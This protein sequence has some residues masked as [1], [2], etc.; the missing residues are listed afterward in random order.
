MSQKLYLSFLHQKHVV[1][2]MEATSESLRL[3]LMESIAATNTE[4]RRG[5]M[6]EFTIKELED[7]IRRQTDDIVR[8]KEEVDKQHSENM[9]VSTVFKDKQMRC[10]EL[11]NEKL[12]LQL[13]YNRMN[14]ENSLHAERVKMLEIEIYEKTKDYRSLQNNFDDKIHDLEI[15]IITKNALLDREMQ[16]NKY[17]ADK[18]VLHEEKIDHLLSQVGLSESKFVMQKEQY[19]KDLD[20]ITRDKELYKRQYDDIVERYDAL[21][22][23][24]ATTE[25][26][27]NQ[28]IS[29]L[30]SKLGN[31]DASGNEN[32]LNTSTSN[33]LPSTSVIHDYDM[34]TA[35]FTEICNKLWLMERKLSQEVSM[36]IELEQSLASNASSHMEIV[37]RAEEYDKLLH[38]YSQT[39]DKM[40]QLF[41]A[42]EEFKRETKTLSSKLAHSER[43]LVSMEQR[44]RDVTTQIQHLLYNKVVSPK[45]SIV[46]IDDN[47]TAEEVINKNLVTFDDVSQLQCRNIEL[48]AVVRKLSNNEAIYPTSPVKT[49]KT[50]DSDVTE[51]LKELSSAT[52][53]LSSAHEV[54]NS[55]TVQ[56][57][58]LKNLLCSSNAE[59]SKKIEEILSPNS[60]NDL[61]VVISKLEHDN[62]T[63]KSELMQSVDKIQQKTNTITSLQGELTENSV[64]FTQLNTDFTMLQEKYNRIADKNSALSAEV[65]SGIDQIKSLNNEIANLRNKMRS[66]DTELNT[67][68]E[69]LARTNTDLVH[70]KSQL[71][72]VKSDEMRLMEQL[73]YAHREIEQKNAIL[74]TVEKIESD[75]KHEE[76]DRIISLTQERDA[77]MKSLEKTKE[78]SAA[79]IMSLQRQCRFFE[80]DIGSCNRKI[81]LSELEICSLREKLLVEQGNSKV[82][83]EKSELFDKQ[84]TMLLKKIA[85]L[86]GVGE[87][88]FITEDELGDKLALE[89]EKALNESLQEELNSSKLHISELLRFSSGTESKLKDVEE[90]LKNINTSNDSEFAKLQGDLANASK[91]IEEERSNY[92]KLQNEYN[93][94]QTSYL[95]EV[96]QNTERQNELMDEVTALKQKNSEYRND[97]EVFKT[98]LIKFQNAAKVAFTNYENEVAIRVELEKKVNSSSNI[99]STTP[100][101]Q[102][103]ELSMEH[104]DQYDNLR[105]INEVLHGQVQSLGL[106]LDR[107]RNG[108]KGVDTSV[109]IDVDRDAEIEE[110]K[111]ECGE[112]REVIRYIKREKDFCET[113]KSEYEIQLAHLKGS[114]KASQLQLEE[115]RAELLKEIERNNGG[116]NKSEEFNKLLVEVM[117][118][119]IV[120]E[121]NAR[122]VSINQQLTDVNSK[123]KKEID[124]YKVTAKPLET[125][126]AQLQKENE[127]LLKH[128]EV[129]SN[130]LLTLHKR[131]EELLGKYKAVDPE[132]YQALLNQV[133]VKDLEIERLQKL[134]ADMDANNDKLR[135]RLQDF[136]NQ[137]ATSK[138]EKIEVD[139]R[140]MDLT[141]SVDTFTKDLDTAKHEIESLKKENDA[142]KATIES[143]KKE[144]ILA[145][146]EIEVFKKEAVSKT[147]ATATVPAVNPAVPTKVGDNSVT[148]SVF[149]DP[150]TKKRKESESGDP[151]ESDKSP[152]KETLGK[153]L[154]EMKHQLRLNMSQKVSSD[155]PPPVPV[156]SILSALSGAPLTK[157]SKV[158]TESET[159]T[160]LN[161]NATEFTPG[162]L[163]KKVKKIPKKIGD[164]DE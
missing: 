122:L 105:R 139:E 141:S 13:Q 142:S 35:D 147:T 144:N 108:P 110:L 29:S 15:E 104:F 67:K 146:T 78:E 10:M 81:N 120:R 31:I 98:E 40:D 36:R 14:R 8:L 12:A 65:N 86:Q 135:T 46:P 117:Q 28:E 51:V 34:E 151:L 96:N 99:F 39:L 18:I 66:L 103:S 1:Y 128:N 161:P 155:A 37:Q 75:M 38:S 7:T 20:S 50:M 152:V 158:T 89:K 149:L 156:S 83:L 94:V 30:M 88:N 47:C 49:I 107:V 102:T 48:L 2:S 73:V 119:N 145:K 87:A 25:S 41:I 134:N 27:Y 114:L 77:L 126:I 53:A 148:T 136:K 63:L 4:K 6:L 159:A 116:R 129:K 71:E 150:I 111:R 118:I 162:K 57:D 17:L 163:T 140:C 43:E 80:E 70:A 21:E 95:N 124:E 115:S 54:V 84:N 68:S 58:M 60:V 153:S 97:L 164:P 101:H 157:K 143:L 62:Q 32:D 55:L 26:I 61:K 113:K 160:L 56:R 19:L 59:V 69:S 45:L 72:S 154:D 85:S 138:K 92:I 90:K 123:L 106:Q 33:L 9:Q 11:D 137:I 24:S 76:S 52:E 100:N 5:T 3:S 74:M 79:T 91:V 132:T 130:D 127:N 93:S 121:S 64:K 44:Y 23:R 82:A 133:E 109:P 22:K 125:Q 131:H 42:N 112:L 16:K